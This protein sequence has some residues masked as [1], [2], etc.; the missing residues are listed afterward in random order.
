MP[1]FTE[2]DPAI[3]RGE[4]GYLP[5]FLD[6]NECCQSESKGWKCTRSSG[7]NGAHAAHGPDGEMYA[8]W[9]DDGKEGV[10]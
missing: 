1:D 3:M 9:N 6:A 8:T 4:R 7:H 2:H 10:A 5:P